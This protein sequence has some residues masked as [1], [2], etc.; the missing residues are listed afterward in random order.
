SMLLQVYRHEKTIIAREKQQQWNRSL[1]FKTKEITG[2]SIAVVGTGAIGKEVARLCKAFHMTTY[3]VSKS[4]RTVE[5]FDENYQIEAINEVLPKVDFI[6]S[7]L[8]STKE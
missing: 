6:V 5:H 8:P 2:R 1:G 3:G 7:V 4:G